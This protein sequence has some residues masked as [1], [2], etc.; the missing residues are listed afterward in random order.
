VKK[1]AKAIVNNARIIELLMVSVWW[2]AARYPRR[3]ETIGCR[4]SPSQRPELR[5]IL[6]SDGQG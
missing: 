3:T 2:H 6:N 5:P 1:P 4:N